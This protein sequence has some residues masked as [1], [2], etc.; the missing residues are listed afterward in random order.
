MKLKKNKSVS[1]QRLKQILG[2]FS[3]LDLLVIGDV[4]LDRYTEGTVDRI[5]PEAPVPIVWVKSEKL[6]MG[7]AANVAENIR[8]LGG[9]AKLIG[10]IGN[11]RGGQDFEQLMKSCKLS[12]TGLVRDTKRPTILKERIVSER[13]Q[14]LRIDY[15]SNLPVS[16]MV[17]NK[18]RDKY[19]AQLKKTAGVI[20]QDYAKGMLTEELMA[21]LISDAHSES[22]TIALDP[23]AKTPLHWYKGVTLLT[24]N[25]KEA[26]ALTKISIRDADSLYEAGR[27][28]MSESRA[29]HAVIT[30]GRDGM[31]L[32]SLKE[33]KPKL[34]PTFAR[35]VYDVSGA[36][37]TVITIMALALNMGATL[38]E[39]AILGN[40]GAGIVVGKRGTATVSPTELSEGIATFVDTA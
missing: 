36:G 15:E 13:Q 9:Q 11:D 20:L 26:E 7:L 3:K 5:S 33:E 10:V 27:K 2:R 40:I 35:E 32:F 12:I 4:G 1:R 37:D 24:P 18:I 19:R 6:K 14:L 23:S 28:L 25:T 29:V 16:H 30:R 21:D 31:A 39:S 38:E 8:S 34:I 17:Q 22:K